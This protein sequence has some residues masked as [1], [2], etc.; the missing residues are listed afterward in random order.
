MEN[1]C[2]MDVGCQGRRW[3]IEYSRRHQEGVLP[4]GQYG[5]LHVCRDLQVSFLI[6]TWIREK[7]PDDRYHYLLQSD[8]D[9]LSLDDYVL[10]TGTSALPVVPALNRADEYRGT[11]I[12]S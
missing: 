4:L 11:P 1:V 5:E 12:Y 8:P 9:L 7:G 3:N 10:N 2:F 6:V